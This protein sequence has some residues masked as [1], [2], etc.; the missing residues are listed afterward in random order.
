MLTNG[1]PL[2]ASR[3]LVFHIYDL[4][5]RKFS[6]GES[7]AVAL[8]LFVLTLG[9]TLVQFWGQRRWVHYD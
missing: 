4:A 5:F 6:F 8:I 7:S 2:D 3:T 9:V 1:G